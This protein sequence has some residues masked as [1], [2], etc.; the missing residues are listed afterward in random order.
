MKMLVI[1]GVRSGKSR[2]AREISES[3]ARERIFIATAI[4]HDPDMNARIERHRSERRDGWTT[5]EEP[6]KIAHL[7]GSGPVVLVDC[8]TLWLTNL[9][10]DRSD[11]TQHSLDSY[12]EFDELA[13]CVTATTG[14]LVMVI[15]DVGGGVHAMTPLGRRFQDLSGFLAQHMASVCDRVVLMCAGIPMQVKP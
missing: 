10:M 1:G 9:M 14:H 7:L 11:Q 15:N 13:A 5:I 8:L 2:Y 3:L 4:P 12:P 6:V